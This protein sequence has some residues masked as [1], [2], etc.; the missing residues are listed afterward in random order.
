MNYRVNARSC[1]TELER[2]GENTNQDITGLRSTHTIALFLFGSKKQTAVSDKHR[3]TR[4][5]KNHDKKEEKKVLTNLHRD[6][7]K[8]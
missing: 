3:V 2:T 8:A 1:L 4:R 5:K 6:I 7:V